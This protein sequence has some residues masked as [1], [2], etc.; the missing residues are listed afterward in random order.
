MGLSWVARIGSIRDEPG[1]STR[2]RLVHLNATTAR[3]PGPD[4]VSGPSDHDTGD[5]RM[6]PLE[7]LPVQNGYAAWAPL[8]DDDGN[9]LTALEG[10]AVRSWFG[11]L[12]GRLA[13]DI[14]CGPGRHTLAL[15]QAGA[16][17]V[18]QLDL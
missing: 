13:I 14:G 4:R 17:Q 6:E 8:Y 2:C 1:S 5:T 15:V 16:A 18:V 3:T 12:V 11:P 7:E 9:P 10:P